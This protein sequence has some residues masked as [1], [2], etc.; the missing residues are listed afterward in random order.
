MTNPAAGG[1]A[2]NVPPEKHFR[3]E[4]AVA[5]YTAIGNRST[6]SSL[7]TVLETHGRSRIVA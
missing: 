3:V 5:A 7:R 1:Y 2:Y 4:G 6:P